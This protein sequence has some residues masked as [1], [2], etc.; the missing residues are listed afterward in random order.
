M[1]KEE[2]VKKLLSMLKRPGQGVASGGAS[3]QPL[4]KTQPASADPELEE[5]ME[6]ELEDKDKKK[7]KKK[8]LDDLWDADSVIAK[9]KK[10]KRQSM[11]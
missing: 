3:V 10:S 4:P 2:K 8:N 7:K 9:I 11:T 6:K 1:T 5:A